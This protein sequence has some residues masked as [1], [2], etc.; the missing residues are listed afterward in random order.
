MQ[1]RELK[2]RRFRGIRRFKWRPNGRV[3][4]LIGPGDSTKTTIL[5]AIEYALTPRWSLPLTDVDFYGGK[6]SGP[7]EITVTVGELPS[8]L[9]RE[10][11]YGL[12]LRGWSAEHGLRDEPEGDDEAVL[13]IQFAADESL[14]PTWVVVNDRRPEGRSI[15]ARDRE[16]LGLVRLGGDLDRHLSWSRGSALSRQTDTLEGV[17]RVLAAAHR[18]ARDMVR[19]ATMPKLEEAAKRAKEAAI[20]MG[21]RVLGEYHPALEAV[22]SG[23]GIG[24]LSLHEGELPVRSLGLGSRRLV[25][26]A[27]Q[28]LAIQGGAVL[29][30]DEVEQGLEPHRV[31]H[32]LRALLAAPAQGQGGGQVFMTTHSPVPIEELSAEHLQCI[33][34]VDGT[35]RARSVPVDL[36]GVVRHAPSALL[37]ARALVC[38]GKTEVGLC[39]GL[40][41]FWAKARGDLPLAH[42]G[43]EIVDGEGHK[44]PGY[45]LQLASLGHPTALFVDS[46]TPLDPDTAALEA[47]NVTVL[48][49]VG[50]AA[51]EERLAQDLPWAALQK[52]VQLAVEERGEQSVIDAVRTR[53]SV[54]VALSGADLDE[55]KAAG[56]TG[57]DIR[58][59]V[60]KAAKSG[61]WY[62]RIDHGE[63]IGEL[64]GSVL[65][66][67]AGTDLGAKLTMVARW[68]Y[69]D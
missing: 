2:V 26:L 57:P 65:Q 34:C 30:L 19:K 47:G 61:D 42:T 63:N 54:N 20:K 53:L 64:I 31:R 25:A 23:G 3:L 18:E 38:E 14:E 8:A 6:Y 10:E 44:A 50:S 48:H 33:R 66:E 4:C 13:T 16:A 9:L 27:L 35:T 11:K 59:A 21:V 15:S 45:A 56:A 43:T 40:A 1:I 36:Q 12:D 67:I 32:L 24:P 37:A 29:L 69:G 46:D 28:S 7:I 39:R 17:A 60:G 49:W 62:K 58:Q 55:W 51:T 41:P 68:C 22:L 52:L 5:D